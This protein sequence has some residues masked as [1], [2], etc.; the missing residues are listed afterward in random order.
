MKDYTQQAINRAEESGWDSTEYYDVQNPDHCYNCDKF[1]FLDPLF[2]Q[3]L[4]KAMGWAKNHLYKRNA[5]TWKDYW[6][7]LIDHLASGKDTESFFK[8][9]LEN[10]Q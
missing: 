10:K 5:I 4:G 1:I 9:L 8:Q 6:H 7:L 2:W 3:A